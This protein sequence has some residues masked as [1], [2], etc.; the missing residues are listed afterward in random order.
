MMD[1]APV[2]VEERV[3]GVLQFGPTRELREAG[4]RQEQGTYESDAITWCDS[5][6]VRGY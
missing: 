3:L 2:G 4:A 1:L 5:T 6:V